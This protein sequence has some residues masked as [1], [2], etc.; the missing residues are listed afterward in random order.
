MI[1][2]SLCSF[3]LQFVGPYRVRVV[4]YVTTI[5]IS[6]P[7]PELVRQNMSKLKVLLLFPPNLNMREPTVGLHKLCQPLRATCKTPSDS[8]MMEKPSHGMAR[9]GGGGLRFKVD[10]QLFKFTACKS[11]CRSVA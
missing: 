6:I 10:F 4:I 3:I 1:I 2:R 5:N 11:D 7:G 9:K 8:L